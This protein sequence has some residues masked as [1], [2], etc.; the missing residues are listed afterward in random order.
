[1]QPDVGDVGPPELIHIGQ[2]HLASQVR[3]DFALVIGVG[4]H[5]ELPLPHAQQIV[6]PQ[7]PIN[8]LRI[9]RPA[10]PTKLS[11]DAWPAIAG[12]L[13]SDALDGVA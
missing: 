11:R 9:H 12:P 7:D 2:H 3:V 10:P 13:Q 5:H 4:R 6:F 8:P 1:M